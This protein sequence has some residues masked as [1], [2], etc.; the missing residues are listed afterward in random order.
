[1]GGVGTSS[2]FAG[3]VIERKA[4]VGAEVLEVPEIRDGPV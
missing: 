4:A 3:T 1:M 2:T